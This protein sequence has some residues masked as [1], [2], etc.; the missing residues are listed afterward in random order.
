MAHENESWLDVSDRMAAALDMPKWSMFRI[1]PVDNV[2]TRLSRED[3]AYS[4]DWVEGKQYWWE[5]VHDP[6]CDNLRS[7][8]KE[9]GMLD[10]FGRVDTLAV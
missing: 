3:G 7:R 10:G 4:V 8:G 1:Y 2:I 5:N 9:I 6:L